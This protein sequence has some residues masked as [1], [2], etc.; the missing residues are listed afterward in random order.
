MT[1]RSFSDIDALKK[2]Y[3][4]LSKTPQ[5]LSSVSHVMRAAAGSGFQKSPWYSVWQGHRQFDLF[6]ERNEKIHG[7]Q[8]HLISSAYSMA[9]LADL[10]RYVD[11]AIKHF[12]SRLEDI[13]DKSIDMGRWVQLFAFDVIGEVTFS[14]RFG[15]MDAGADDGTFAQIQGAIRSASWLG[16]VPWL[17]WLHD[18]LSPVIGNYLAITARHGSIRN[19]AVREIG[20]RKDRGTDHKDLLGKLFDIR[21][22]KPKEFDM[23]GVASMAT[24]NVFAGS[25]TTA[26]SIR[27]VIYY[28][29]KNPKCKQKLVGEIDDLHAKGAVSD[30]VMLAEAEQMPY[31]Q[32]CLHEALRCHPAVGMTLPRVVPPGAGI[33]ISGRRVAPGTIVGASPWVIHQ[34]K[35]VFGSDADSFNPERWL[36]GNTS[37]MRR[38]FFTFGGGA[39][40]CVGRNI[41]WMEMSKLIPT[42]F[43][44]YNLELT[45][46]TAEWSIQSWWFAVQT[47]LNVRLTSRALC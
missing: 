11:D 6:G 15:F 5:S 17:Y 27:A 12:C 19:F 36:D 25:D 39:R 43:Q 42:L 20:A 44:R 22:Q 13:R 9:S 4:K 23:T 18:Y 14:K 33:D 2:I 31:F 46:P 24:S 26:L 3:G 16:Q 10:E 38:V 34:D 37:E 32:A 28:L 45:D 8:R 30:P 7:S 41:A 40:T 29:L 47:G 1:D 21:D 35:T